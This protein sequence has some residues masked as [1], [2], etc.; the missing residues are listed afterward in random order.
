MF[1]GK[2]MSVSLQKLVQEEHKLTAEYIE[3]DK[4]GELLHKYLCKPAVYQKTQTA[5]SPAPLVAPLALRGHFLSYSL[6]T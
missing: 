5:N 6:D 3:V 4:V 1:Q 2:F